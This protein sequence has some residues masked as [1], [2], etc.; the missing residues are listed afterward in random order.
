MT[1]TC[2]DR[3]HVDDSDVRVG[4]SGGLLEEG[5]ESLREDIRADVT[6]RNIRENVVYVVH[7]GLLDQ[8]LGVHA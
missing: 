8:V 4:F 6:K 3:T 7:L 1:T 5:E 2:M